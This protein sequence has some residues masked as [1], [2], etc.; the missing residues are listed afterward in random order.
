MSVLE[1]LDSES[2]E[3]SFTKFNNEM[4]LH[5]VLILNSNDA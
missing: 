2:P 5:I 1:A 4:W 3:M